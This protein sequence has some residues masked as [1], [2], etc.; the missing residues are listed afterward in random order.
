[1]T[2][3]ILKTIITRIKVATLLRLFK[4]K[5]SVY[6]FISTKLCPRSIILFIFTAHKKGGGEL[7]RSR[8]HENEPL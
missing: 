5:V 1:M 7:C 2:K 3:F 8:W 4:G 6:D